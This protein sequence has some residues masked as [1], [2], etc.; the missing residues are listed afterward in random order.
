MHV[1]NWVLTIRKP[2]ATHKAMKKILASLLCLVTTSVFAADIA[3]NPVTKPLPA[4]AQSGSFLSEVRLGAFAHDPAS[5]E[6]GSVDLNAELLSAKLW[7]SADP[8]WS[9]LIP[10]AHIGGTANFNGKTSHGYAGL[11]WNYDIWRGLFIEG[12]FGG[13]VHNGET[14][15]SVPRNMN[16]MGC[17]VTFRESGSVGYRFTDNLSLMATVEHLSNAGLCKQNRGLTNF[18]LRV[19]YTF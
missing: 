4:P 6:K 13:A 12:S 14:G 2:C 11:T 10:R 7:S 5:P 3:R 16:A 9:F 15:K 8:S 18:G 1:C 17:A 19:G